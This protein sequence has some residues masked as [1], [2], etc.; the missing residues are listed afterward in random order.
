MYATC[1][2]AFFSYIIADVHTFFILKAFETANKMHYDN[3]EN[4]DRK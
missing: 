3:N 4:N 2:G 1:V